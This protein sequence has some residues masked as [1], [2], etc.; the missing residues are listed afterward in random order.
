M[1]HLK[2]IMFI[3]I[4]T[5]PVVADY[6]MLNAPLQHEWL[7]KA[8]N[9]R[10][11]DINADPE[12]AFAQRAGVYS[13]FAK[14][15]CIGIGSFALSKE[16]VWQLRLKAISGNDEQALLT[17]FVNVVQRMHAG[18]TT[19]R[20]CG[21]NIKEFDLPFLSRR[22]IINQIGLPQSLDTQGKKPWEVSHLDTMDMWRF[23]DY[24]NYT[25]LSLLA[26]VLGIP[27][28]KDDIDGSMVGDVYWK[29]N[30][31]PRISKYCLQDVLTTAKVYLKLS[32]QHQVVVNPHIVNE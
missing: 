14:V 3:D 7:R 23:G 27:S 15:V 9:L 28:P 2:G 25:P 24:K 8:K 32:G 26:A 18:G 13:E 29:Q 4:E 6:S 20:Y 11:E 21:H 5:A 16:R 12:K 1:E 22:C 17:T 10:N 30:D 31:L 19:V